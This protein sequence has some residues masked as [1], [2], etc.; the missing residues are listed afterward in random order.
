[1]DNQ[2]RIN[3]TAMT[4]TTQRQTPNNDFGQV[5]ARTIGEAVHKGA[6]LASGLAMGSPVVSAAVSGLNAVTSNIVPVGS[7]GAP[8][9]AASTGSSG[10]AGVG[11]ASGKGDAW[12]LMEANRLLQE[13]QR[14][15]NLEY[16]RLQNAMQAESREFTAISNIMKVRH[17]SAKAAI[18]NIR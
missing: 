7:K 3:Q 18:N 15:F 4:V 14:A 9:T 5:L 12:D 16:L 1:M 2:N 10:A 13:E 8:Q 17:D 11:G 6:A